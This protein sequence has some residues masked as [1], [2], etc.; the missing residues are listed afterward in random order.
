[1]KQSINEFIEYQ[2]PFIFDSGQT[3][4]SNLTTSDGSGFFVNLETPLVVPPEAKYVYITV[5]SARIWYN[6]YNIVLNVND[7]IDITYDDGILVVNEV[8]TFQ[9]GLYDLDHLNSALV[10]LM[11]EVGLPG[12]LFD[13]VPDTASERVVIEF[14]YT[15]IQIDF[16]AARNFR[17]ILGFNSRSV[18]LAPTTSTDQYEYGDTQADFNQDLNYYVIHTDLVSRGIRVNNKYNQAISLINIDVAPGSLINYVAKTENPRIPANELIGA[19]KKNFEF[20]LT[21]NNNERVNTNGQSWSVNV[22]VH[23]LA[24]LTHTLRSI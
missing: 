24:P 3:E 14:N 18:P 6:S 10:R 17:E 7:Q 4:S 5:P 23:Y 13:F 1:M 9:P 16:T 11:L 12:D 22:I 19:R 15:G 20:W 8:L 21:N 2:V